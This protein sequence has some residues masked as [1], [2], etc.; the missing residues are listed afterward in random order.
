[1]ALGGR[2]IGAESPLR[3]RL[4]RGLRDGGLPDPIESAGTALDGALMLGENGHT[5]PYA[6]LIHRW[7]GQQ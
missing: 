5:G 4:L 3:Q 6:H 1:M 7:R 2:L